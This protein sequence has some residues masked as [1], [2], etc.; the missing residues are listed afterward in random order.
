MGERQRERAGHKEN[1]GKVVGEA[2]QRTHS[3][4][5]LLQLPATHLDIF[6]V[7]A[8][9]VY[10]INELNGLHTLVLETYVLWRSGPARIRE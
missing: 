3:R 2:R 10:P 1:N 5:M 6:L 9:L 7:V 4:T 8:P